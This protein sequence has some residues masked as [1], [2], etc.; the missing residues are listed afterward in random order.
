MDLN[1]EPKPQ[2]TLES[3]PPDAP[4]VVT[5]VAPWVRLIK[6]V[7]PWV[8]PL[9]L[10]ILM[11]QTAGPDE[12]WSKLIWLPALTF[13]WAAWYVQ[14]AYAT[15]E[16]RAL[17]TIRKRIKPT[18]VLAKM[19]YAT[20]LLVIV[21]LLVRHSFHDVPGGAA[22]SSFVLPIL[23]YVGYLVMLFMPQY[24]ETFT[25]AAKNEFARKKHQAATEQIQQDSLRKVQQQKRMHFDDVLEN[26]WS[27]WYIRYGVGAL[28]LWFA[29][30]MLTTSAT[31][32]W[33]M[34]LLI[35]LCGIGCMKELALWAVGLAICGGLAYAAIG[36][37]AAIPVG[38]AI[39]I[40]AL[41]IAN[42]RSR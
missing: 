18:G 25:P 39:I 35:G 40:G 31:G 36:A 14:K 24:S 2:P 41:I 3:A 28:L 22:S 12:S 38:A 32:A 37:L 8:L 10:S 23:A 20:V 21:C 42:S 17:H 5:R 16:I 11:W 7:A 6:M 34:P 30:E 29:V 27:R 33:G 9:G 4:Y 19:G 26:V 1:D 13:L 15:T